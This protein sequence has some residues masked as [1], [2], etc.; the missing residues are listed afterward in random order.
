MNHT[1]PE[2]KPSAAREPLGPAGVAVRA[3]ERISEWT[4]WLAS[5]LVIVL[6]ALVAIDVIARYVLNLSWVWMQELEWH[7]FGLV[8]LIGAAYTLKHDAHVRVDLLARSPRF[9]PRLRAWREL[10]GAVFLLLPFCVLVISAS[11]PFVESAYAFGERSPYASGLPHRFLIK[12]AI[13]VGF[14][15]LALQGVACALRSALVLA[16]RGDRS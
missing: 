4:G 12:A 10:L 11:L 5:R 13:P 1:E 3:L 7:L 9:G 15:L 2:R 16:H 6:V 8:F 14:A